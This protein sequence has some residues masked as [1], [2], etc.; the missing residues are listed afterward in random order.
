MNKKLRRLLA[1]VLAAAV[2]SLAASGVMAAE[3]EDELS[4]RYSAND[5]L[6]ELRNSLKLKTLEVD[7]ALG[8]A[9]SSH[10]AYMAV[11]RRVSE[12]EKVSARGFTGITALDRARYA[13]Y[14]GRLVL[15]VNAGRCENYAELLT[16][17][18]H[19]P[20]LRYA[21]L[22]PGASSA[23]YGIQG[24]YA[25][26]LLGVQETQWTDQ[27]VAYPYPGQQ[28]VGNSLLSY[29]GQIPEE[30]RQAGR[31][32]MLGEPITFTY[33]T[34]DGAELEF[35]NVEFHLTDTK[36][37][38]EVAVYMETPQEQ[39]RMAQTLTF[40]PLETYN[41]DTRYEVSLQ[42]EVWRQD[43]FLTE[44]KENW[45]YT[46]SGPDSIGEVSRLDA[47]KELTE[48]F[49]VS[50]EPLENLPEQE[51]MD[52]PYDAQN[53]DSVRIYR[54]LQ[55]YVLRD[56]ERTVLRAAEGVTRE[57][58]AIWMMRMLM[59]Y[60]RDLYYSVTLRFDTTFQDIDKCSAEGKT[61]VQRAYLLGLVQDQGGGTFSPG[62]YITRSEFEVWLKAL[63]EFIAQGHSGEQ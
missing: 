28:K 22:Y 44:V 46:S 54:L 45:S 38:K 39:F 11:N 6:N 43:E 10:A 14:G 23:G 60:E 62:V 2:L 18:L 56:K 20:L 41:T 5:E 16:R 47:L 51:L 35:R 4:S 34:Q 13:G 27:M 58:M 40:Y 26:I 37:G 24:E 15:E 7:A 55:T 30:V 49:Q 3:Q 52:Y 12:N 31:W 57:Q 32:Y 50:S 42:C 25:S 19:V 1:L 8:N 33:Y 53:A 61:A 21:L 36:R 48:V 29:L 9:A 17:A 63:A 59:Q